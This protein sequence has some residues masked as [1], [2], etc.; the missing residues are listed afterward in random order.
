MEAENL[1]PEAENSSVEDTQ[2]TQTPTDDWKDEFG[3]EGELF[4]RFKS[5]TDLAKSYS[6]LNNYLSNSIRIPSEEAGEEAWND[7]NTKL[8]KVDGMVRLPAEDDADG[9]NN[10]YQRIGRP[11]SPEGYQYEPPEGF[12][13]NPESDAE[14]SKMAFEAGLTREQAAKVYGHL[15]GNIQEANTAITQEQQKGM[16]ELKREW[17]QAFD[18][19]LSIAQ[20]A[21]KM[22]DEKVPGL[23]D[24]FDS[25]ANQGGDH[26]MVRLMNEFGKLAGETGAITTEKTGVMTPAEAKM[27]IAEIRDNPDHPYNNNMHPAHNAANEK[28]RELYLYAFPK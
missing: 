16:D 13:T 21:T 1:E 4:D 2:T 19:E 17:G 22:M 3:I 8:Q 7:F 15:T 18:H 25:V 26:M 12:E 10:F 24:Y 27:R 11:A 14:F 20:N 28:V 5:P 9:W 23:L 6:E